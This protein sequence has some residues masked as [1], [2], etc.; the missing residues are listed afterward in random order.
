M[1]KRWFKSVRVDGATPHLRHGYDDRTYTEY[2][3]PQFKQVPLNEFAN[4][5]RLNGELEDGVSIPDDAMIDLRYDTYF[6][7]EVEREETPAEQKRRER[8]YAKNLAKAEADLAKAQKKHASLVA[9]PPQVESNA[10]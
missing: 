1:K 9:N 2:Q 8:N 4:H 3:S 10:E 5:V 7:I 6:R